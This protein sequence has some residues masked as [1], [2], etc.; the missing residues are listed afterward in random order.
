MSQ[1]HAFE[2]LNDVLASW[3]GVLAL[4][5]PTPQT[6]AM[7]DFP[8]TLGACA[9][10]GDAKPQAGLILWLENFMFCPE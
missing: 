1:L 4:P 3:T 7:F 10:H 5:C 6:T 8:K 9:L 2:Y